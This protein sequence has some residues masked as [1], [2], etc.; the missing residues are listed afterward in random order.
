MASLDRLL[1]FGGQEREAE[2]ARRGQKTSE[3][4]ERLSLP[5][6]LAASDGDRLL[7]LLQ[8]GGAGQRLSAL[9]T[10]LPQQLL[11]ARAAPPAAAARAA[12]EALE[13]LLPAVAP[14][15]LAVDAP[16]EERRA[17]LLAL[18]VLAGSGLLAPP[19]VA[20]RLVAPTA[21]RRAGRRGAGRG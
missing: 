16:A 19:A 3:E 21:A 13:R 12:A 17:A 2:Q 15:A 20:A 18:G 10:L 7:L 11:G 1:T 5:A 6:D 4:L 14:I 8:R 9:R